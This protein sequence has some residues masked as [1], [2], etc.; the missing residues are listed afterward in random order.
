M[1]SVLLIYIGDHL[2]SCSDIGHDDEYDNRQDV[3]ILHGLNTNVFYILNIGKQW[4]LD[5]IL[6]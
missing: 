2:Y 5:L 1:R 3:V 4:L 6:V